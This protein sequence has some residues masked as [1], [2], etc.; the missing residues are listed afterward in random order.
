[1]DLFQWFGNFL[2]HEFQSHPARTIFD[3]FLI[4]FVL[5]VVFQK[6]YKVKTKPELSPKEVEEILQEWKPEP[7]VPDQIEEWKPKT[8][9]KDVV[10]F[11]T[12]NFLG[13]GKNK[14]ILDE[15]AKTIKKY[16]VGSCGP[17][18]FY[19]T[20]DVHLD[21]EK[22]LSTFMGTKESIL[23]SLGFATVS[24]VIQAFSKI[25]DLI[26]YDQGCNFSIQTGIGLARS[27]TM[28]FKHNDMEDLEKILKKVTENDKEVVTQR[29]FLI[30][31]GLYQN[32]GDITPLDKV[33]E[34]KDKYNFRL[35]LDDSFGFGVLGKQGK[36]VI[37]YFNVDINQVDFF[38]AN[39]EN[40]IASIGGFCTGSTSI[41]DHQRLAGK[42]YCFSASSPP[43]LSTAAIEAL[44]I[45]E[46]D[47]EL[48]EK[49][50]TNIKEMQESLKKVSTKK[51]QFKFYPNS[52]IFHLALEGNYNKK[53]TTEILEKIVDKV[54]EKGFAITR[55]KYADQD[56]SQPLQTI[57]F[58]VSVE[59]T[60][61]DIQN[62]IT[63]LSKSIEEIIN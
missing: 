13:F 46:N 11:S 44:K 9:P 26:V 61:Q 30:V 1:M 24:S 33:I 27:K 49:L 25:E 31:E 39:L 42:G 35:I 51:V 3:T 18:G 17:R 14:Q 54:L 15:C 55:S 58:T 60:L 16:G 40:A 32:Y 53:E 50:R 7:L 22:K 8:L 63:S 37:E 19:G 34:L 21:L 56:H 38:V 6:S 12:F 45:L 36:G 47:K 59:H 10:Q 28:V 57:R 2:L 48:L 4:I 29:R 62:F 20:I 43:Y 23:Y 5:Y 52:P 41:V